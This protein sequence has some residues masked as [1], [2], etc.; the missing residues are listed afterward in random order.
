MEYNSKI[1]IKLLRDD[2]SLKEDGTS[3][4]DQDEKK[5]LKLLNYSVRLSDHIHWQQKSDQLNLLKNFVDLKIDGKQFV[6][7]FNKIHKPNEKTIKML[8]TDL[9]QLNIF[10]PNPKSFRFTKYTSEI[11]LACDEFYPD[12]QPQD[13][14]EL[15]FARDEENF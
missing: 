7:Q 2:Q 1:Y 5:Y 8:K 15:A 10:K 13:Q 3:L 6:S 12:F 4:K 11:D 9:K 14:V